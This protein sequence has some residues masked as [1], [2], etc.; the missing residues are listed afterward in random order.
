[1]SLPLLFTPLALRGVVAP[2]RIAVS[3]MVQNRSQDGFSNDFY[4]VHYGKFALGKFGIVF[5]EATAVEARGRVTDGDLGIWA[6][7]HIDGL[8]RVVRFVH[9][10]GSLAAIQLAHAGRKGAMQRAFDGNGPLD[11]TDFAKGRKPW[12][13]VGPTTQPV[14]PGWLV[15]QALSIAEIGEIVASFASAARRSDRCGF[16]ICEIHGAHG[17]LIA[18]FLSPISNTRNDAYGGDRAGRMRIALEITRAVRE[19]WPSHKPLFFRVSS[20]DGAGGWSLEDTVALSQEL[21]RL[22]VDVV[23]CSSGGLT[24]SATAAPIRRGPG[25][26]VPFASAVRNQGGV[27]SMAVGLILDGAQAEAVLQAGDADIIAVGRQALQ[28]P[29]WPLYAA[30]ALGCDPDFKLWNQEVGWWL[31]K[32][33]HTLGRK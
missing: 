29:Y 15:P 33:E 16:D 8:A 7:A 20:L 22:G 12:P 21:G 31:E 3:P 32:R 26:Q 4:L 17:Y 30:Q 24:G 18:S 11:A 23:D 9:E 2:N 28:E 5:T 1:V 6:D 13:V 25:F 10:E 19:A 14:A 27:K